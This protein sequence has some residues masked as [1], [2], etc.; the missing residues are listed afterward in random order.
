MFKKSW[1]Q[2][3]RLGDAPGA[4]LN[5]QFGWK[6]F[7]KDLIDWFNTIKKIDKMVRYARDH[8]G[9]WI[10]RK[11]NLRNEQT[12][13]VKYVASCC[14][15]LLNTYFHNP[16]AQTR[17][18]TKTWDKIWFVGVMKFYI[19][20]L[21]QDPADSVLTSRLLRRLYGLEL[22]PSVVWE[23]T[24]WSWLTDWCLNIGNIISNLEMSAYD[25]LVAKYAYV[26]RHKGVID[27]YYHAESYNIDNPAS[28][29]TTTKKS[30]VFTST[31]QCGFETK[32]RAP[33]SFWG[34]GTSDELSLKQA[35]ILAAL[36]LSKNSWGVR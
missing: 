1:N 27:Y 20:D 17:V 2:S 9:K 6:P 25:N 18:V 36:G 13:E 4:Y 5:Y 26:M 3:T 33:A 14:N 29:C 19:P 23:L 22:G 32:E 30:D 15:P 31:A 11:G 21:D 35:A 12:T 7:V 16:A 10:R 28:N 24:P 8:N 34:F